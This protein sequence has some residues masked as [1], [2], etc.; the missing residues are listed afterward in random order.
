MFRKPPKWL[1]FLILMMIV[2]TPQ[3]ALVQ[4]TQAFLPAVLA[5]TG[6]SSDALATILGFAGA[7]LIMYT[8]DNA[9]EVAKVY[10]A[11]HPDVTIGSIANGIYTVS[12]SA[13]DSAK[14]WLNSAY[15]TFKSGT[16]IYNQNVGTHVAATSDFNAVDVPSSPLVTNLTIANEGTHV[17]YFNNMYNYP[18]SGMANYALAG[19]NPTLRLTASG[20]PGYYSLTLLANGYRISYDGGF[21]DF[22]SGWDASYLDGMRL[23]ITKAYDPVMGKVGLNAQFQ[24]RDSMDYVWSNSLQ[25]ISIDSDAISVTLEGRTTD[26]MVANYDIPL[27]YNPATDLAYNPATTK[28]YSIPVPTTWDNVLG[29]TLDQIATTTTPPASLTVLDYLK[30]FW[31]WLTRFWDWVQTIPKYL[32]DIKTA[33]IDSAKSITDVLTADTALDTEPLKLAANS[34]TTRFPFSLPWDLYR[35]LNVVNV[36]SSFDPLEVSFYNPIDHSPIAFTID[37]KPFTDVLAPITRAGFLILY[38]VGLVFVTRKLMGGG[39]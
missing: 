34:L 16:D 18:N 27:V 17:I 11:A 20:W 36:Q 37:P 14:T 5:L 35:A 6:L 1:V 2:L 21:S 9:I 19:K 29:K 8:A 25:S 26:E 23:V 24:Y 4:E 12:A 33:V 30:N 22:S 32:T 13:L 38:G 15:P 3:L 39:V 28:D 7:G 10:M 31:D